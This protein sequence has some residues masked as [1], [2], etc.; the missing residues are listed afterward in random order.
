MGIK[1]SFDLLKTTASEWVEDKAPMRAAALAYYAIFSLAPLLLIAVAVAGL[2]L[3]REAA[4]GALEQQLSQFV[5]PQG[6]QTIQQIMANTD[7]AGANIIATV[8]GLIILLVGASGLFSH[9]QDMLNTIWEVKPAP[10]AGI[11]N[12]L[13]SRLSSF[14]MVLGVGLLLL[15]TIV[16]SAALSFITG[17]LGDR[18]PGS[19]ALWQWV[20]LGVSFIVLTLL[21]A[22]IF[23]VLPDVKIGWRYVWLGALITALL[24]TIGK[25]LLGLYLGRSS[26]GSAYG[27]AGSLIVLLVWIYYSAQILFFG[28]EFTQVYAQRRHAPISPKR[29]AVPA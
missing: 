3:G 29:G 13:R 22:L 4:S 11:K 6:A 27:A 24:F 28:A 1:S 17:Y 5:G 18:I 23:K 21:F 2:V 19:A 14:L 9:L 12:K 20:N 15:A 26:M 25:F 8:V 10:Q 16:L 7:R